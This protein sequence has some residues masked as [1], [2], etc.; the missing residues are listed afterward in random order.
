MDRIELARAEDAAWGYLMQLVSSL[1][2]QQLEEPGYSADGWSVKDLMAHIAAWLAE[3][4]QVFEQIRYGTYRPERR[5]VDALN[6]RFYDANK[7]LPAPV[8]RAECAASRN[9]MLIEWSALPEVTVEASEWFVESGPEHYA[10]HLPRLKEWVRSL[11][12]R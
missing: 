11:R 8:V 2:P 7:D 3:A 12:S 9:R 4:T 6:R 5:D 1:T 10:E